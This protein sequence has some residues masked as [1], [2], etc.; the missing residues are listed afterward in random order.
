MAVFTRLLVPVDG[1]DASEA[2]VELAA[3]LAHDVAAKELSFCYVVDVESDYRVA[4]AAEGGADASELVEE[5]EH[6][7][8]TYVERAIAR[9]AAAGVASTAVVLEG[10]P[11]GAIAKLAR[12]H[13]IDLIVVG[14]HRPKGIERLLFG[15]TAEKI[16]RH[17]D[18]PVLMVKR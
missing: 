17:T 8:H 1:S 6:E 18:V 13:A 2:A 9:A 15:S 5:T 7:G 12:E 16:M 11:P 10:D 3:T 14:T 4:A